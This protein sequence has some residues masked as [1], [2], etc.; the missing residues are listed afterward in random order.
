MVPQ[1][2]IGASDAVK[3]SPRGGSSQQVF[4][5]QGKG[6]YPYYNTCGTVYVGWSFTLVS[7]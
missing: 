2:W 5:Y 3:F 7:E 4:C 6:G 1:F